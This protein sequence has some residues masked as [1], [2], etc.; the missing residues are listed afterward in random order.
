MAL[1]GV[2]IFLFTIVFFAY[3]SSSYLD[4]INNLD[5]MLK[6][7]TLKGEYLLQDQ[8]ELMQKMDE[9]EIEVYELDSLIKHDG[10]DD[11]NEFLNMNAHEKLHKRLESSK[12]PNYRDYMEYRYKYIEEIF[13]NY[14]KHNELTEIFKKNEKASRELSMANINLNFIALN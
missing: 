8:K 6:M 5:K 13:P 1:S 10:L 2:F 4:D 12:D 14:K 7:E 11:Y 9:L 3:Q